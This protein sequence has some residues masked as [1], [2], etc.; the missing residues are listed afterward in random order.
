[1]YWAAVGYGNLWYRNYPEAYYVRL[2]S[3]SHKLAG[4]GPLPDL[5]QQSDTRMPAADVAANLQHNVADAV[6]DLARVGADYV[7][8]LQPTLGET[9]KPLTEW[10][11]SREPRIPGGAE[12]TGQ[13]FAAIDTALRGF[14]APGFHYVDLRPIFDKGTRPYFI[15]WCHFG[16]V[17]NA[18]IAD[19]LANAA[20]PILQE[21]IAGGRGTAKAH[22][23]ATAH[24]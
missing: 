19:G 13:C 4:H 14:E 11:T 3:L 17:G 24:F 9:A 8:A 12:Y 16:D 10:E 15:D 20:M 2:L 22:L 6:R 18:I 23:P 5:I 1:M 7:F 21:R